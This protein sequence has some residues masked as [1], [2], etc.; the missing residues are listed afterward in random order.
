ML[1]NQD[2]IDRFDSQDALSVAAGQFSQLEHE[3][4]LPDTKTTKLDAV[5]V[6]GMGGSALAADYAPAVWEM[7]IPYMVSRGYKLPSWV[8]NRTLVI[9]SSYSGNTEEVLSTLDDAIAKKVN[10]VGISSGGRLE[11]ELKNHNFPHIMIPGGVQPRASYLFQLKAL[12]TILDGYGVMK[13]GV[14]QLK[15]MASRMQDVTNVWGAKTPTAQNLAKQIAESLAGKTS[16]VYGGVLYPAAYKWKISINENAKNTAWCGQYSEFNHN[17]FQG[18]ASHPVEK[19]FAIIDLISSF[20]HPQIQR[21]FALSDK[22]LSGRRPKALQI[23]A[24]G[25]NLLEQLLWVTALGDMVSIYLA[26]LNGIN[27]TP[28]ELIENL[29]KELTS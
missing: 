5:V 12:A 3:F 4:V 26:I 10:I 15:I 25:D 19:P 14:G 23:Q 22:L 9:L 13:D 27:P 29:K 11:D 16:I 24:E 18:W 8:N 21:R 6:A 2:Y 28:V 17:E 20:D 7:N 1:D